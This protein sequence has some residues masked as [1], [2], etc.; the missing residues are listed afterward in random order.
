MQKKRM[1]ITGVSGLLGNNLAFCL[2]DIYR[3]LGVYHTHRVEIDGIQTCAA[4]LT[5]GD[6]LRE[7]ITKF[8]PE[9]EIGRASCRERV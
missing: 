8:K 3:V 4:D 9:I 5:T 2:K 1:L 7:L 6:G